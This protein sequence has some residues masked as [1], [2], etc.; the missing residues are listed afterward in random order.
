MRSPQRWRSA[1]LV[2][3]GPHYLSAKLG[4]RSVIA[5]SKKA[6]PRKKDSTV[7]ARIAI[8]RDFNTTLS[9]QRDR[10]TRAYRPLVFKRGQAPGARLAGALIWR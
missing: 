8:P 4:R 10:E 9:E 6:S 1:R 2:I 7:A 5:L 3:P